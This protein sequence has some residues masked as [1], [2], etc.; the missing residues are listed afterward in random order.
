MEY[1]Y[2]LLKECHGLRFKA[3]VDKEKVEGII[4]ATKDYVALCYGPM[5]MAHF[6]LFQK[7]FVYLCTKDDDIPFDIEIIPRDPETYSDWQIGDVGT[8]NDHPFRVSVRINDIV[9]VVYTD[10]DEDYISGVPYA[11]QE[12]F[13]N[14]ARL[15]LTDIEKE[16][17]KEESKKV[18][19]FTFKKGDPVLVRDTLTDV[20][21]LEAFVEEVSDS[22]RYPYKT[23]NGASEAKYNHCIP[24]NEK[25]K[26]LL[27]TN[28]KYQ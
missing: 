23:T 20:W 14:G 5:N 1:T 10:D 18:S 17:L 7:E 2:K 19:K 24:Y 12:L 4:K 28:K 9:I 11:C 13:N 25:T 15:I 3:T 6:T 26:H 27:G 8:T 22:T 16:L 21:M